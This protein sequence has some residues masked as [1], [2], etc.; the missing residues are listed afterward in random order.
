[1]SDSPNGSFPDTSWGLVARATEVD[2]ETRRLAVSEL[3]ERYWP[4]LYAFARHRGYSPQDAE[5]HTQVFFAHLL[6]QNT[7]KRADASRGKLRTFLLGAFKLYMA[8]EHQHQSRLKRGG[9]AVTVS[10]NRELGEEHFLA[11]PSR[12]LTPDAIFDHCWLLL[13]L[14]RTLQQLG[15]KYEQK[16]KRRHFEVF[17]H[18]LD[19]RE[20]QSYEAASRALGMSNGAVR[21]AVHRF[22]REYR[23]ILRSE[24]R[25]TLVDDQDPEWELKQLAALAGSS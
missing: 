23:E 1:M 5:D 10:L 6:Q 12:D 16:D 9:G 4:P 24:I 11:I 22:T 7:V 3:C 17:K 14:D 8:R 13:L 21:V 19:D 18:F 25:E 15:A 20:N 2:Q